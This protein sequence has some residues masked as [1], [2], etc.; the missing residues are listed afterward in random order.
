M[1]KCTDDLELIRRRPG[2]PGGTLPLSVGHP[3]HHAIVHLGV[4]QTHR[5]DLAFTKS[6]PESLGRFSQQAA[7]SRSKLQ[8]LGL[9]KLD[10][11][12]GFV[13][14]HGQWLLAEDVLASLE[15]R[16]GDLVVAAGV[17]QVEYQLNPGIVHHVIQRAKP[18]DAVKN[19]KLRRAV[20]IA[21]GDADQLQFRIC[22]QG[23][24]VVVRDESTTNDCYIHIKSARSDCSPP[25]Y[26]SAADPAGRSEEAVRGEAG[27]GSSRSVSPAADQYHDEGPDEDPEI[28][29]QGAVIDV[30]SIQLDHVG[31][32]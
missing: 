9:G 24:E 10:E 30:I 14:S 5:S 20:R 31:V 4:N 7:G 28:P 6:L 18:G 27:P 15:R 13:E 16:P 23:R 3:E 11:R 22:R 1:L 12:F 26:W 2:D 29:G 32:I 17:G 19:G 21:I 25:R 8:T